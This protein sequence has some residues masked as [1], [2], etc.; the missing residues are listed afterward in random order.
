MAAPLAW[1]C[2]ILTS[3]SLSGYVCYPH[4]E[5]L[6]APLW[7]G[8]HPV[9]VAV[10]GVCVAVAILGGV[11]STRNWRRTFQELPGSAHHLLDI[12]EGRTRFMAMCGML[13]SAL[14]VY[15][16]LFAIAALWLVPP[17]GV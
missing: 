5:P 16:I 15:A 17:C 12:G 1:S 2:Q 7:S 9:L 13:I 3:S 6:G 14:F 8:W 11:I 10:A 4:A